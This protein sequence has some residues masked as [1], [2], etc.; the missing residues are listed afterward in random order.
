MQP[1]GQ[2]TDELMA[3]IEAGKR[4]PWTPE[5]EAK[6]QRADR[7]S[8]AMNCYAESGLTL[9]RG[10]RFGSPLVANKVHPELV[11]AL[12]TW[13]PADGSRLICASKGTGKTLA[14]MAL[15]ARLWGDYVERGRNKRE[16]RIAYTTVPRILAARKEAGWGKRPSEF[17]AWE[18]ARIL[19]IDEMGKMA[20]NRERDLWELVDWRY[21]NDDP[22]GRRFITFGIGGHAA[23][24]DATALDAIYGDEF[25]ERLASRK[26]AKLIE[27]WT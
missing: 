9:P 17:A 18:G 1:A 14:V 19:F 23:D 10:C 6:A 26:G 27:V 22:G 12:E 4:N 21:S 20:D 5:D 2:L 3:A 24:G 13:Q 7:R 16:A 8:Y 11:G 25:V 15:A